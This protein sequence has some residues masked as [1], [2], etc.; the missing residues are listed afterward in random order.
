MAPKLNAGWYHE[1]RSASQIL[2]SSAFHIKSVRFCCHS[3]SHHIKSSVVSDKFLS[4]PL[5]RIITLIS[6]GGGEDELLRG[7]D[8][9]GRLL[10]DV[11]S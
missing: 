6:H 10:V 1:I 9:H 8:L 4:T 7:C 5:Y 2:F 3:H 11:A